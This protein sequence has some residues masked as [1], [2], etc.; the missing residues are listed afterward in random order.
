MDRR[1]KLRP[2]RIRDAEHAAS[3]ELTLAS[4]A[5]ATL[6]AIATDGV[7]ALDRARVAEAL[8]VSVRTLY[9][10]TP[11]VDH[12]VA[13][14]A[15]EWQRR[16][17]L[18]PDT[19]D[20]VR[21]LKAWCVSSRAHAA[22]HPGLIAAVQK[23]PPD[24]IGDATEA[25]VRAVVSRLDSVGFDPPEARALFDVL[26]THAVGSA[27]MFP[28]SRG[29]AGSLGAPSSIVP[30]RSRAQGF[31]LGLDLLLESIAARTERWR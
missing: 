31:E 11:T 30:R 29:S 3:A 19:G 10:L 20:W 5:D 28:A 16:W 15:M 23:L 13:A 6:R 9:R 4:I 7:E 21:D 24:L 12:L 27:L 26:S 8:A 14:A 25:V 2:E 1:P 22:A 17:P 18:P